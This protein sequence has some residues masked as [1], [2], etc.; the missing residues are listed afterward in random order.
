MTAERLQRLRQLFFPASSPRVHGLSMA[1]F[2]VL[3]V[4]YDLS[5]IP[6]LVLS[7]GKVWT[8]VTSLPW[9]LGYLISAMA[10]GLAGLDLALLRRRGLQRQ[11]MFTLAV[12]LLIQAPAVVLVN[13]VLSGQMHRYHSLNALG[14]AAFASAVLMVL[15]VVLPNRLQALHGGQRLPSESA[16]HRSDDPL[17]E[18][19][20]DW[21][22]YVLSGVL[23]AGLMLITGIA[24]NSPEE[25]FALVFKAYPMLPDY[26]GMTF[27]NGSLCVALAAF[28]AT[29][30]D[31]RIISESI[32]KLLMLVP[33]LLFFLGL[34]LLPLL[35]PAMAWILPANR[36]LI[37][38]SL[39]HL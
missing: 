4:V 1:A 30:R 7:G 13:P 17:H 21:L 23:G 35:H 19:V 3:S 26:F 8:S 6:R 24:L 15:P 25:N 2:L 32:E 37:T 28:A 39:M 5:V 29:L 31:R 11:V 18:Q 9:L 27:I 36:A 20:S 14:I 12:M 33:V 34:V 22:G 16:L 10:G 38:E